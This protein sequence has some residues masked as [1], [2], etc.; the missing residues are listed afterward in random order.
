MN[1]SPELQKRILTGVIGGVALLGL[2]LFAG[3]LGIF[4]LTTVVSLGMLFEFTEITLFMSDRIEKRYMLLSIGWFV[5]LINLLAPQIEFQLLILSFMGLFIYFL[6]TAKR[7]GELNFQTHFKELM[8]SLFGLLY[9]VFMPLYLPRIYESPNGT[10]WTILFL[11]I[12]WAGD[13]G[14]Y[15]VGK[16]YGKKKL[17]SQISPK[18]TIEGS[19]G[20]IAAGIV[21]TLLFKLIF[22][23]GI[24]WP[25]VVLFPILVGL[26]AQVGDLCESFFKRAFD[27]KD[28]GSILPG[29]GGFLDRFDGVVFS[30]PVMYACM[31]VLG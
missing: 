20:G 3:W 29:H 23:R 12:V 31:R 15:F 13:T 28:S 9:L 7:H 18:K 10:E 17:Y 14:A 19:L 21:V 1:L 25:G 30:L 11:L 6:L 2:I 5:A 27:K 16:K 26:V 22:F 24:S 8:Y 4:F